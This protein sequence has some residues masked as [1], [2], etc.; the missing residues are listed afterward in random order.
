MSN[1]TKIRLYHV[2]C[3]EAAKEPNRWGRHLVFGVV[4]LSASQALAQMIE[5]G[6][7]M[8][9]RRHWLLG[10]YGLSDVLREQAATIGMA[11]QK[12]S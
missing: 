12:S 7:D 4:C 9:A 1:E 11:S 3:W 8:E 5:A 10:L 2:K 6:L